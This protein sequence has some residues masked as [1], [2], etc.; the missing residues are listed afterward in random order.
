[1]DLMA[2]DPSR[3][4]ALSLWQGKEVAELKSE[5]RRLAATSAVTT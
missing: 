4:V 3:R 1:M 5:Q 2:H